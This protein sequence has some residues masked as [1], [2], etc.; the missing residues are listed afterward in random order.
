MMYTTMY[1][2][3]VHRFNTKGNAA[4]HGTTTDFFDKNSGV[5]SQ[6]ATLK[7]D[8]ESVL[9]SRASPHKQ[10]PYSRFLKTQTKLIE[11]LKHRMG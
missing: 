2:P 7:L 1:N 6:N 3:D 9:A 11:T 10:E 8:P 5:L 4:K